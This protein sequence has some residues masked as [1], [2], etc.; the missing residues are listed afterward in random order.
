MKTQMLTRSGAFKNVEVNSWE[1]YSPTIGAQTFDVVRLDR[2][3][4]AIVDDEGLLKPNFFWIHKGYPNPLAGPALFFGSDEE[5]ETLELAWE[6]L[7]K[8][9][10]DIKMIDPL[11]LQL[12]AKVYNPND[13]R[14]YFFPESIPGCFEN[15]TYDQVKAGECQCQINQG[16]R[17]DEQ[18]PF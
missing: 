10:K 13:Y 14:P 5:G 6:D 2:N 11:D 8:I 9:H 4:I 18:C 7:A 1:D 15:C 3:I 16:E 12:T 17:H